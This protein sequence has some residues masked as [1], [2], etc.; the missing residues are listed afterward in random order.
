MGKIALVNQKSVL[1]IPKR[2]LYELK[3]MNWSEKEYA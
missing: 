3:V 2:G 1:H